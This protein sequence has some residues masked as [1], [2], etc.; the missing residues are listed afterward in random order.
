MN[1]DAG[2]IY[3]KLNIIVVNITLISY[4]YVNLLFLSLCDRRYCPTDVEDSVSLIISGNFVT[5]F[6]AQNSNAVASVLDDKIFRR[7]DELDAAL[8]EL[9]LDG[10]LLEERI[11][12]GQYNI[13]R[14]SQYC[15]SA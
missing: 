4:I 10:R 15:C 13:T 8:Q 6:S 7:L 1:C 12:S 2:Y 14:E 11:R 3:A 5:L 9:E